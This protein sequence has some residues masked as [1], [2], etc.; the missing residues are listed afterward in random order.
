MLKMLIFL[1]GRP[2]FVYCYLSNQINLIE[3]FINIIQLPQ[4]KQIEISRKDKR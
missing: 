2:I 4:K 1:H 3:K